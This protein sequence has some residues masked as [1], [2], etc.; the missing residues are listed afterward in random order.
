MIR[1][2][3]PSDT[4]F[5]MIE[6]GGRG[7]PGFAPVWAERVTIEQ[8]GQTASA[9]VFERTWSIPSAYREGGPFDVLRVCQEFLPGPDGAMLPG[10]P[11][12]SVGPEGLWADY[13]HEAIA[14]L[15]RALADVLAPQ[16]AAQP[17]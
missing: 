5:R 14:E 11:W 6:P 9:F 15:L 2:S 10:Q 1:S 4:A 3:S 17:D 13:R 16:V 12:V 8:R 7:W